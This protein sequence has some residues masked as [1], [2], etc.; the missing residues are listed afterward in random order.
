MYGDRHDVLMRSV[1][2]LSLVNS[3]SLAFTN[4]SKLT[5]DPRP[6]GI[7]CTHTAVPQEVWKISVEETRVLQVQMWCSNW[8]QNVLFVQ[9]MV[10]LV[11]FILTSCGHGTRVSAR[12]KF[13]MQHRYVPRDAMHVSMQ[14]CLWNQIEWDL[15]LSGLHHTTWN[16]DKIGAVF[17]TLKNKRV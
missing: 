12:I 6:P 17:C 7:H 4:F 3:C 2:A 8:H 5:K 13:A 16:R 9:Q 10:R 1:L 15:H 11:R 14:R